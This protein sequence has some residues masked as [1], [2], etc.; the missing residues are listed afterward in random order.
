MNIGN[1]NNIFS[2]FMKTNQLSA[3]SQRLV[4]RLNSENQA[5]KSVKQAPKNVDKFIASN[6]NSKQNY[7]TYQ[8]STTFKEIPEPLS[9][10]T[11]PQAITS[12]TI[13]LEITP[14][15]DKIQD[16]TELVKRTPLPHDKVSQIPFNNIV[17]GHYF[18]NLNNAKLSD[19]GNLLTGPFTSEALN[20]T[21]QLSNQMFN[22]QIRNRDAISCNKDLQENLTSLA[23]AYDTMYKDMTAE[24]NGQ[25]HFLDDAMRSQLYFSAQQSMFATVKIEDYPDEASYIAD[26]DAILA[27]NVRKADEFADVFLKNYKKYGMD[28][29]A[30]AF[31]AINK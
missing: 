17:N 16:I 14:P 29:V 2:N 24:N 1:M 15:A 7:T 10:A 9:Q 21:Y 31:E 26:R 8:F 3:Y 12:Q 18:G 20:K 4:D 25:T 5:S 11:V 30:M 23:N 28:A 13:E 27:E 6:E 22:V 19:D